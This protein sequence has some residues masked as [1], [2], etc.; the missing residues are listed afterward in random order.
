AAM[1]ELRNGLIA[2]QTVVQA[3]DE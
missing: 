3:W 2:R 1:L